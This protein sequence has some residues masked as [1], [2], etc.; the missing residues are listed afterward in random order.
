M[1]PEEAP[2]FLGAAIPTEVLLLS[3]TCTNSVFVCVSLK[4]CMCVLMQVSIKSCNKTSSFLLFSVFSS[5]DFPSVDLYDSAI[6]A[7]EQVS[8]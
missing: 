4:V 2:H 3:K 6:W 8:S 5:E 7:T 1:S